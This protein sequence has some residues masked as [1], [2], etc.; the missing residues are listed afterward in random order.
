MRDRQHAE[1]MATKETLLAL[2]ESLDESVPE[3]ALEIVEAR[4]EEIV[5]EKQDR[6]AFD[7]EMACN[8]LARRLS[9]ARKGT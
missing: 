1:I 3:R 8:D 4:K 7:L 2:R 6:Q 5:H 9:E